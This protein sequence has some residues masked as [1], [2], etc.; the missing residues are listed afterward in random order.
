MK[1]INMEY[2]PKGKLARQFGT[3]DKCV[4]MKLIDGAHFTWEFVAGKSCAFA[5][6]CKF[7]KKED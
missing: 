5:N 6:S 3:L 1:C 7:Y 2:R 4:Y